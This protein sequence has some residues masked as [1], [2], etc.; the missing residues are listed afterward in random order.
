MAKVS[1]ASELVMDATY[2]T[3]SSGADLFAVLAEA[4]G[5]GVPIGYIFVEKRG[6]ADSGRRSEDGA[7]TALIA[8]FLKQVW[9]AGF[10]PR[11]FGTDKD[12]AE[13]S[14]LGSIFSAA[15][16]QLCWWHVKRAIRQKLKDSKPTDPL[17]SYFPEE[18]EWIIPHFHTCWG[19]YHHRRPVHSS[20]FHGQCFCLSRSREFRG[21]GRLETSRVDERNNVLNL[22]DKHFNLHSFI[23]DGNG[24]FLSPK[25]VYGTAVT[26]MYNYCYSRDWF[27]VW[28]YMWT[29]WYR[30]QAWKLWARSANADKIPVLRTTMISE[31][32]WCVI[33]HDCL[34]QFNPPRIDLVVWVLDRFAI[35]RAMSK[36]TNNIEGNPRLGRSSWRK[37]FKREFTKLQSLPV[38]QEKLLTYHT[39][40][41]KW[42]CGCL[43]FLKNRFLL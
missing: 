19:S 5:A 34:H 25:E 26:E 35:P 28:A 13:I 24:Y 42:T 32:H 39:D 41:V 6:V 11:F 8:E 18:C 40:P 43:A 4:D 29:N 3:N 14:A 23:P 21:R 37:A 30:P 20:H 31:S 36:L 22:V 17:S 7:M 10:R 27:R 12:S 2:G 16:H 9:N 1:D 38:S 33:K 15:K